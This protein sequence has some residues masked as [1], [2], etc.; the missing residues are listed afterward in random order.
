MIYWT[1]FHIPASLVVPA[2]IIHK[3]V[4]Q[5]EKFVHKPGSMLS[6]LPPRAKALAPVIAACLSI[7][8]VVP[9]VDHTAEAILEPTLGA[10]LGLQFHHHHQKHNTLAEG[11]VSK[12]KKH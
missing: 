9:A 10:Y 6:S 2:V 3:V 8:P 4:H 12:D 11:D 5:A 7:I 1:A